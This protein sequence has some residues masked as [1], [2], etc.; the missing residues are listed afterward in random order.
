MLEGA[1]RNPAYTLLLMRRGFLGK[2]HATLEWPRITSF[3]QGIVGAYKEPP[4]LQL[5]TSKER[6]MSPDIVPVMP[7]SLAHAGYAFLP[8]LIAGERACERFIEFFTANIR[9][10]NTRL[11]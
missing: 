8:T 10:K 9:N 3:M 7:R 2:Y 4:Y 6:L 11:A 1:E 5:T